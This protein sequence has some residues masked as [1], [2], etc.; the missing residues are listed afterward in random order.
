MVPIRWLIVTL[1]FS[2][3]LVGSAVYVGVWVNSIDSRLQAAEIKNSNHD[4]GFKEA[5]DERKAIITQLNRIENHLSRVEG[6][7]SI[8]EQRVLR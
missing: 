6:K 4:Q 7:L 2:L 1:S 3:S 8:I 5:A